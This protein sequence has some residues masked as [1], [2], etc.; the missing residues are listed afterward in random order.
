MLRI[1]K[2]MPLPRFSLQIS[3]LTGIISP[4]RPPDCWTNLYF[5][6][7][8]IFH[9]N[10]NDVTVT[11]L[12]SCLKGSMSSKHTIHLFR[13]DKKKLW[14]TQYNGNSTNFGEKKIVEDYQKSKLWSG[15]MPSKEM[16]GSFYHFI[17]FWGKFIEVHHSAAYMYLWACSIHV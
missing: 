3:L 8:A 5:Q 14:W 10:P 4:H 1:R 16:I 17:K 11:I 13:R 12:W 15:T 9:E 7:H 2:Q 6:I